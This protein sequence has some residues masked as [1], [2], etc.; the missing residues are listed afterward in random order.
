[1]KENGKTIKQME[2]VHIV[3]KMELY[4]R[5]NGKMINRY[6]FIF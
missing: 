2:R 4:L 5:D 6:A 1:M 3:T